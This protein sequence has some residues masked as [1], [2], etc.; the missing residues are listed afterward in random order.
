MTPSLVTFIGWHGCGKT[1]LAAQV[2]RQLK[3]RGW[4]VAV[5]KSTKDSGLFSD[6]PGTD[7]AIHRQAGADAVALLTP[8]RLTIIVERQEKDLAAIAR[9]FFADM[10]IVIGEGFK[11]AVDVPKI[12]VHRGGL[13]LR[14]QVSGV[15]A[16]A[17]DCGLTE[18]N[19]FS[20]DESSK[21]ADFIEKRF[22]K[23]ISLQ[24]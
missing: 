20:L 2:V 17:S 22:L 21:L 6:Q 18:E 14:G 24:G 4:R 3:E 8:E 15:I 11:E 5:V 23:K 9:R 12:E 1:T 7:T 16:V 13:R 10:D 19:S